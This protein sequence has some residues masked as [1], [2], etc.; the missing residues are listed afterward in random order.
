[1]FTFRPAQLLRHAEG[2]KLVS[3]LGPYGARAWAAAEAAVGMPLAELD[4]LTVAWTN[5][6]GD[7]TVTYLVQPS[8]DSTIE[9]LEKKWRDFQPTPETNEKYFVGGDR[10]YYAPAAEGGRLFIVA[11]AAKMPEV[12]AAGKDKAPLWR[13]MLKLVRTSDSERLCTLI[14]TKHALVV[15]ARPEL[16]ALDLEPLHVAITALFPEEYRGASLSVHLDERCYLEAR[17]IANPQTTTPEDLAAALRRR[18]NKMPLD[19]EEYVSRIGLDP[20]GGRVLIRLGTMSRFVEEQLRVG[21]DDDQ[22]VLNCYLPAIAAHNLALGVELATLQRQVDTRTSDDLAPRVEPKSVAQRLQ[23]PI[24]VV[25]TGDTLERALQSISAEIGVPIEILGSDL[26]SEGIT[27]N[28]RFDLD[29]QNMPAAEAIRAVLLKASPQGK[30]VYVAKPKSPGGDEVVF[31]TTRAAAQRRGDA[32]PS[33]F[34][35]P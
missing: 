35:E 15:D 12:L 19:V 34:S 31:I 18:M 2:Q 24:S 20:Y 27:R 29:I 6:D 21:I 9:M 14:F 25:Q 1:V 30:L 5:D 3:A 4:R 33:E 13:E 22:V 32:F 10:G 7:W 26:V 28:N 17:L 11:A 16:A 23:S 8:A